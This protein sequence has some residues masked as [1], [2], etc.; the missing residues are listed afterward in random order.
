M[1]KRECYVKWYEKNEDTLITLSSSH[2][3]QTVW[4]HKTEQLKEQDK[5]IADLEAEL[6][7][8]RQG[9]REHIFGDSEKGK[10]EIVLLREQLKE[11]NAAIRWMDLPEGDREY[12][13]C[14]PHL[15]AIERAKKESK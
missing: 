6:E 14:T 15:T 5:R 7:R 4:A 11:A 9:G 13:N 3:M 12:D 2:A 8:L 1:D 10:H